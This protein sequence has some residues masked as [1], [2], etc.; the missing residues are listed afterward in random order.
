M[1][2]APRSIFTR[3]VGAAILL[4]LVL[5]AALWWLTHASVSATLEDAARSKVDVDLAGMVDIYATG[6]QADLEARIADRIAFTPAEGGAAHYLLADDGGRRIAGDLEKWPA[7]DPAVSESGVI[8]IGTQEKA[9]ARAVQ[10]APGLRLL[11]ARGTD[12]E[13][14]VLASITAAFAGGGA[15]FVGLVALLG[16]LAAHGLHGRIA[17]IN[18]A[19]REPQ[20]AAGLV[21]AGKADGDEIDELAAHSAAA[22]L[23]VNDLL[24]AYKDT[25]EQLA[26]E[27]RT[28]LSHLDNRLVKALASQPEPAVAERLAEARGEI[29]RIVQTL[30]SLL[31]IAASKAH[32]GD[33]AGL[34]P[35]DLSGLVSGICD[36]YA[37]SAEEAGLDLAWTVAPGV[38]IAGDARQLRRLVTNMLDNAIKYVPPGGHVTVT[39]EP[40]PMLVIADDGPGIDPRDR[41]RIFERFYRGRGS[42]EETP[43]SGLGLALAQ[44]IAERHGLALTLEAPAE[45]GPGGAVFRIAPAP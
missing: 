7:L 31:D 11:V 13:T 40:G 37:G 42:G 24:A 2:G 44:A 17:R 27:I 35:V 33:R 4:S 8:A 12:L 34:A 6:G 22:L 39:L 28:P 45:G 15:V 14:P 18:L 19:F 26:H 21:T 9:Y 3:L 10:L 1:T 43:G 41:E 25:S 30:E 38:L 23:R 20:D 36:L 5:L 16:R 32:R 29:R